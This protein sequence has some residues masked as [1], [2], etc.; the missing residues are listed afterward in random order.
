MK[1]K[2]TILIQYISMILFFTGLLIIIIKS[3]YINMVDFADFK[4]FGALVYLFCSFILNQW[5]NYKNR[6]LIKLSNKKISDNVFIRTWQIK[7][8]FSFFIY[9]IGIIILLAEMLK[10]QKEIS[11]LIALAAST[12]KA[13]FVIKEFCNLKL[14]ISDKNHKR[15]IVKN[16]FIFEWLLPNQSPKALK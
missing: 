16:I 6:K 10:I 1:E 11:L 9:Y 12:I 4:L 2:A 14:T 3:A 7:F 13:Y 8:L 5:I 15:K